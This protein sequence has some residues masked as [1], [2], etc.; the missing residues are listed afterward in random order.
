MSP[1]FLALAI[2]I[3]IFSI[4]AHEVM[5]GFI[6]LKFGDATAERAGRLTFNPLPH[7]DPIG[8]I[9]LPLIFIVLPKL[10]GSP[11]SFFIA[12]AKPVPIN[13]LNFTDLRRGE[14][15]V[16]AAGI[17]TNFF[18][19]LLAALIYRLIEPSL[20]F[21]HLVSQLLSFTFTVNLILGTF[22]LLPIPPL[23]G[24]KIL[25]SQLPY[26][27]AKEYEKLEPYGIIILMALLWLTPIAGIAIGFV[28]ETLGFY[29]RVPLR[30]F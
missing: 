22:N 20:G 26:S 1:E 15:F 30:L 25:L 28:L 16:S 8:S 19:A 10:T 21:N 18:L 2:I 9:L 6:A 24:S 12:W 4:I 13:P 27:L 14:L 17:L 3:F 7:I 11:T 23:D 29:L 5:H